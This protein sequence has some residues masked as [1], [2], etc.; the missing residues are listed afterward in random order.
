MRFLPAL[1]VLVVL[2]AGGSI[3]AQDSPKSD[4][5]V[6]TILQQSAA[7]M[8]AGNLAQVQDSLVQGTASAPGKSES[9]AFTIK[10][11][12]TN[13]FR[14]EAAEPGQAPTVA[15]V[16]RGRPS[17]QTREGWKGGP[18][19]NTRHRRADHI[20]ALMLAQEL[21]RADLSAT[22]VGLEDVEGRGAHRIRL[23]RVS[24]TLGNELDQ[25]LTKNSEMDVFV[26]A[27]TFLVVK[28]SYVHLTETDWRRGLP[29][30]I[31]YSDYRNLGG[32]L[33]PTFQRRVFNGQPLSDMRIS[34][35]AFNVGL[36]DSEFE[37]R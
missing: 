7:V 35:V 13:L 15:V 5:Q 24:S 21:L 33:I 8:G 27:Q 9:R 25:R 10:A 1:V 34:S 37:G 11:K 31:H 17:R 32:V 36:A 18:S 3:K 28:L 22:Y 14:L 6:V 29:M 20:P 19:A 23:A 30:E 4:L 26:D 16:N 2:L 12:G